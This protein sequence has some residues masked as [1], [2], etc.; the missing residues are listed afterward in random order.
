[1]QN[2]RKKDI[3]LERTKEGERQ[4]E[5][6]LWRR[7]REREREKEKKETEIEERERERERES[8]LIKKGDSWFFLLISFIFIIVLD[9]KKSIQKKEINNTIR[10]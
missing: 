4:S 1:M 6:I 5:E 3:E 9:K 8:I 7:E 2:N 10:V